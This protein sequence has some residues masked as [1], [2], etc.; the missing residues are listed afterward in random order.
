MKHIVTDLNDPN[1][2]VL[3]NNSILGN[4]CSDTFFGDFTVDIS[5]LVESNKQYEILH[6]TQIVEPNCNIVDSK[7]TNLDLDTNIWTFILMDPSLMRVQVLVVSSKIL[8]VI[9]H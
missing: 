3:F 1:E 5:P 8:K 6:C 7:N 4:Y 2:P 9:K